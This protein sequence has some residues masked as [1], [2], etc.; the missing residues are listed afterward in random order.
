MFSSS[1]F[2]MKLGLAF[3]GALQAP[4]ARAVEAAARRP[5]DSE[6]VS[7]CTLFPVF[8]N[9]FHAIGEKRSSFSPYRRKMM[10]VRGPR[11]ID[12]RFSISL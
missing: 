8:V 6:H 5:P 7:H 2:V 10:T 9:H 4:G 11:P 3:V 12:S 1:V